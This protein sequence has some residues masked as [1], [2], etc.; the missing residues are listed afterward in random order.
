MGHKP[1]VDAM[2]R[3][4]Y[5]DPIC[6]QMMGETA[7]TLATRYEISRI[8][9]DAYAARSQQCTEAA[10]K[11]GRF[12]AEI[13]PIEISTRKGTEIVSRDEHPRD[14]VTVEALARLAP[15][16]KK[17]GSVTAG[18]SSGITD[19]AA[20][21][22]VL[23]ADAAKKIGV[24]PLARIGAYRVDAVEPEVMGLG[25]VPAV[26]NLLRDSGVE[27][28]RIDLVE[29]NEAFAAQ[30]IAVERELGLDP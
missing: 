14:G 3:D 16:F 18:N 21:L 23:S 24:E 19:G 29:L 12:D 11:A 5:V 22:L 27:L 13:A 28:D 7:E 4:G 17:D 1:L 9:Q 2:Y 6:D 10:R 25:P 26:H 15:A 8:E 20:A 30:V